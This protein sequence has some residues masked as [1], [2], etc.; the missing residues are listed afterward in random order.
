MA[1]DE[2]KKEPTDEEAPDEFDVDIRPGATPEERRDPLT[3]LCGTGPPCGTPNT[4]GL[5]GQ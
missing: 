2:Q 5:C 1:D 4:E 3:R